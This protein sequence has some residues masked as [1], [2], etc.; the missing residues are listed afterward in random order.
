MNLRGLAVIGFS[1][2]TFGGTSA[3]L[4]GGLLLPGAGSVST[5][6]AGAAV[7][8]TDNGEALVENPAGLAKVTGTELTFDIAAWDYSLSF[9]RNG[10]YDTDPA[11]PAPWQGQPYPTMTNDPHLKL[12]VGPFQ[13]VPV[14]AVTSDLGERVPGL[15]V[16]AGIFAPAA[17]PFRD[18]NT[19][20]GKPYFVSNS[21]GSYSFPTF[22]DPPPPT[23][24]DIIHQEAA[25]ILPSVAAS[26]RI[27]PQLDVG[28]RF[29]AGFAQLKS[30]IALWGQPANYIESNRSDGLFSVDASS[31]VT[32]W[33]LGTTYRPTPA[34]E[35]AAQYTSA[36]SINASGNAYAANGPDVNLGGV[37]VV[38]IPQPDDAARC[39]KGGTQQVLKA[40][41]DLDLPMSATLA[42][43]YKFLG[44]EGHEQGDV[45]LDVEW[46]NWSDNRASNYLTVVDAQ[47]ATASNPT[48]GIALRDNE[49]RHG[50][51]D[52]Y[53]VR[54]GG[55]YR[56][57]VNDDQVIL[58]GGVGYETAAAK[59]GWERVDVDGAARTMISAGATY[60]MKKLELDLGFGVVLEGTRTDVRT[61]NPTSAAMGCA[62]TPGYPAGTPGRDLPPAQQQGPNPI[63]PLINTDQQ[64]ENPVNEGTFKSHYLVMMLGTRYHF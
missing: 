21:N 55:S 37:A 50:F 61:C 26:Y 63:N 28:G 46:Q 7:A 27:L 43:R 15:H 36:L 52:T 41:V 39:A 2:V 44:P 22:G 16:A 49:V 11:N 1:A 20:N 12:G 3:A 34:I 9:K 38:V 58:R 24:Y 23:R 57:P 59:T 42:S 33:Q 45:E 29:S 8:S 32:Q 35:V 31:F 30:T 60:K 17:F 6:R 40:C 25:I 10:T 48:S 19:V 64:A 13:P 14:I 47:V 62:N 4:A 51:K 5:M 18:M 56:M 54:L 53:G